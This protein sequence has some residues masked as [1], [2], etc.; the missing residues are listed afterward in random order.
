VCESVCEKLSKISKNM[1][2]QPKSAKGRIF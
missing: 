2:N 1:E